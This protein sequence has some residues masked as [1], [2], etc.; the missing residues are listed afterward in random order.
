MVL[1]IICGKYGSKNEQK[2]KEKESIGILN[3][4]GLTKNME[5]YQINI[6]LL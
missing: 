4:S 5:E 2:I 3:I 1:S 6:W